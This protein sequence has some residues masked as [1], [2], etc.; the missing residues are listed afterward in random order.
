MRGSSLIEGEKS[1]KEIHK[2]KMI[3]L[4]EMNDMNLTPRYAVIKSQSDRYV[5]ARNKK[6]LHY[7]I[8]VSKFVQGKRHEKTF[9]VIFT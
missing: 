9:Q 4:W 1:G 5:E 6:A 3:L 7:S 8:Y 2:Q